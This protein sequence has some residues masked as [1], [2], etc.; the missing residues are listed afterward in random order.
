MTKRSSM[1]YALFG[2]W[3]AAGASAAPSVRMS[4]E[5]YT[6]NTPYPV[7]GAIVAVAEHPEI[8]TITDANGRYTLDVPDHSEITLFAEMPGYRTM[9]LQTFETEGEDL[10][11]VRFQLVPQ[12]VYDYLAASMGVDPNSLLCQMVTTVSVN[13]VRELD[14]AGFIAYGPHGEPGAT[15]TVKPELPGPIYF[16]EYVF[17]DPSLDRTTNDGGV[18]FT[19]VPPG[20]YM[21]TAHHPEKQFAKAKL[22]CE[23]GRFVNASPP[24][25]LWGR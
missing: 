9:H 24:W 14:F 23:P 16:N 2:L 19:N 18:L 25:G 6:F 21:L 8:A 4:G 12:P 3:L 5:V 10:S 13:A 1:I 22:K 20:T 17:P 15:V 11:R 7:A